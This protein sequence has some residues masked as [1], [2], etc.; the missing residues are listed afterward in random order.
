MSTYINK[1]INPET[2]KLQLAL[3]IDDYYGS[4]RYGVGFKN[5]GTD[6]SLYDRI[7]IDDYT[8]YPLEEIK[9]EPDTH[10]GKTA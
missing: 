2:G 8:I 1:A 5:N 10:I 6:A 4:H 3:F 9:M 7:N